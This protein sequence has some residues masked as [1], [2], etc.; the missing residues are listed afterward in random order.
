MRLNDVM[1]V[2]DCISDTYSKAIESQLVSKNHP[3]YFQRDVVVTSNKLG[4]PGLSHFFFDANSGGV[5]SP[6]LYNLVLPVVF[7][8]CAKVGISPNGILQ[9]R[10]FM[11]FPIADALRKEYDHIHVDTDQEHIVALYYVNDT[12]GDTFIFDKTTRDVPYGADVTK[13]TFT[14][15]D[16]ITPK[17]GRIVFFNGDQYHASSGPTKDMRCI[18]NFN[19]V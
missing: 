17:R 1:V 19:L 11:H 3:W 16:R 5:I 15:K 14:V 6:E 12:D 4:T 13:H 18:I 8:A 7:E 9:A 2:D 10:S